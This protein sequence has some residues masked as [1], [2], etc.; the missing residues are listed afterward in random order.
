MISVSSLVN[1]RTV[2]LLLLTL[3]LTM[4]ETTTTSTPSVANDAPS[5]NSGTRASTRTNPRTHRQHQRFPGQETDI[6]KVL[7][8]GENLKASHYNK[9]KYQTLAVTGHY[10]TGD[11]T[12]VLKAVEAGTDHVFT[13]PTLSATPT[14]GEKMEY[15]IS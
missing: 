14:E 6:W 8:T 4:A 1:R 2:I 10:C 5:S 11:I 15:K 3:L 9:I 12:H 7:V 13:K